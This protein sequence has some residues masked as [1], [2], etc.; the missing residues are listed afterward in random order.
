M[1][2]VL[3]SIKPKLCRILLQLEKKTISSFLSSPD[4]LNDHNISIF[5]KPRVFNYFGGRGNCIGR[6]ELSLT[7]S[8][9]VIIPQPVEQARESAAVQRNVEVLL[10]APF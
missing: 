4:S 10:P 8:N 7:R 1:S 6:A 5:F 9:A 3:A 2:E